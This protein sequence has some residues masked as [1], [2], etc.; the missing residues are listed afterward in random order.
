M[1]SSR[2]EATIQRRL[3]AFELD[4]SIEAGPE[5][6]VLF[7]ASG[8]GK[9][10]T[11]R[12]I[13]GI[14]RPH[15]GRISIDGAVL[16]DSGSG[17]NVP[18]HRRPT[19]LVVQDYGLF[20]HLTALANVEFG[21][22]RENRGRALE[23]LG[24]LQV[25]ELAGRRPAGLSGGQ[26]QRVALARALARQAPVLL[27]DEPF[28][29]LDE[30]LRSNLRHE[31]VRLRAELGLTILFVTHD[32]REAHL[33]ADRLAVF[34]GGRILQL[35]ARD[36]VFRRP[37]SRRVAELTGV[38]NIFEGV[39]RGADGGGV[40]VEVGGIVLRCAA[41]D[42]GGYAAGD[43]VGVA[44]RA[45]RVILRRA[46]AGAPLQNPIEARITHEFAYGAT[47][48]LRFAPLGPGPAVEAELAA[49][50]YEV[51]NVASQKTWTLELPPEDLHVMRRP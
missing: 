44:V 19:A 11:L 3:G 6:L 49:R 29:A 45:E 2:L 46:G 26:Q 43:L 16:F 8:S 20:P 12:A 36:T 5:I 31:L 33:L 18:A 24:L 27:L 37:S 28:S 22:A 47:H 32:L 38:A 23:A 40:D 35:D 17:A 48:T 50:P 14:D 34:D 42:S 15:A 41:G 21:L 7:G 30:A 10:L 13:A 1:S 25:G 4:V 51:L 9:S 39:V